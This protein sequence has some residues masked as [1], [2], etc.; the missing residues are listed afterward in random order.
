MAREIAQV[1]DGFD[2]QLMARLRTRR[3]K[4]G[5]AIIHAVLNRWSEI[6]PSFISAKLAASPYVFPQEITGR[7]MRDSQSPHQS[8]G[9][10]SLTSSG[11]D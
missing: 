9:L 2:P 3:K 7:N 10:S 4:R 6:S 5:L 1:T 8:L 11:P